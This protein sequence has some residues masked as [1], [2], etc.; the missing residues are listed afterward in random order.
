M[1]KAVMFTIT[2]FL[3]GTILLA[4][5]FLLF[6]TAQSTE[7]RATELSINNRVND[8]STSVSKG[9]AD[10]FLSKSGINISINQNII[11]IQERVPNSNLED[12]ENS[13]NNFKSFVESRER[14]VEI[15]NSSIEETILEIV[16]MNVTFY[17]DNADEDADIRFISNFVNI[18]SIMIEI[19]NPNIPVGNIIWTE[20]VPGNTSIIITF[21]NDTKTLTDSKS[22]DIAEDFEVKL[23][24]APD[25]DDIEIEL[26]EDHLLK[27]S[28]LNY[29][30][31][32]DITIEF[33]T[34]ETLKLFL[35]GLVRVN[36]PEFNITKITKPR[37]V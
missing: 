15:D 13:T 30:T 19:Y 21:R 11:N 5:G 12:Y 3:L 1:A 29:D 20:F 32:L 33:N 36:V 10:L 6:D 16:P 17:N 14:Y 8:I 35:N 34:T 37:I 28:D 23:A 26:E 25:V 24:I 22:I 27:I 7:K 31:I 18:E 9:I 2:F 4:T